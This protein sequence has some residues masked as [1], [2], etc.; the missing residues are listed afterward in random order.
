M[1]EAPEK[2]IFEPRVEVFSP[3]QAPF[4]VKADGVVAEDVEKA[5]VCCACTA[6][7]ACR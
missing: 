6:C 1:H 5:A 2:K 3:F 4:S 7:T